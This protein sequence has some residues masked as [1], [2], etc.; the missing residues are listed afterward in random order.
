MRPVTCVEEGVDGQSFGTSKTRLT[1][2]TEGG[3]VGSCIRAKRQGTRGEL[4]GI[5]Y[6]Y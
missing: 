5:A 6:R 1:K 4:S 3:G 2:G